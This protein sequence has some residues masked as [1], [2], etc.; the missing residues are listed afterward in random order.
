[1]NYW[2]SNK[3]IKNKYKTTLFVVSF[4]YDIIGDHMKVYYDLVML[5][6]IVFDFLLLLTVSCVL[7]RNV[8]WYRLCL[9]GLVGGISIL[10]LFI[11]LSSSILFLLKFIISII[12]VIVTFSFKDIKYFLNNLF[13]LYI[14]SIVLGGFLY[15]LNLEFSYKNEGIIFFHNGLSINFIVLIIFSPIILYIYIR[16]CKS[17]KLNYSHYYKVDLWYKNKQYKFNAFLDTGN[18]LYDPYKKRPIILVKTDKIKFKYEDS[19]L[20]PYKTA[21][22]NSILKCLI[23]DKIVVDNKFEVLNVLFGSPEK[24]FEIDG[25]N[26]ILHSEIIGGMK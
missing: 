2:M 4:L 22:G 17:M 24:A 23:A 7:K 26:M 5:L 13:Y 19:I 14:S 18:K 25:V 3:F 6:N 9:G 1:M 21:S 16:Q 11:N 8:K 12:M 15:M 20:V 10:A